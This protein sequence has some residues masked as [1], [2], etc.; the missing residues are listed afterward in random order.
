MKQNRI[1]VG[2]IGTGSWTIQAHLPV[3]ERCK[4]AKVSAICDPN[5]ERAQEVANR[6]G[7]PEAYS[8]H[9]LFAKQECHRGLKRQLWWDVKALLQ[10]ALL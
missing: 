5:L 3:F 9:L 1:N 10:L 4:N 6:F 8:N 7:I 2:V